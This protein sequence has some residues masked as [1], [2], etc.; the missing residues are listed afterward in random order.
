MS[1][2]ITLIVAWLSSICQV[3]LVYKPHGSFRLVNYMKTMIHMDITWTDRVA[4][5]IYVT[6]LSG[7][8]QIWALAMNKYIMMKWQTL[9]PLFV[10]MNCIHL[11]VVHT[12]ALWSR[13]KRAIHRL[14]PAFVGLIIN[15]RLFS[16]HWRTPSLESWLSSEHACGI[17][18]QRGCPWILALEVLTCLP[19]LSAHHHALSRSRRPPAHDIVHASGAHAL[20]PPWQ[21]HMGNCFLV[22]AISVPAEAASCND[23][24]ATPMRVT[25]W[26]LLISSLSL[27][28]P[29]PQSSFSCC[30]HML[31]N[32][33]ILYFLML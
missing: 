30:I 4:A 33:Q 13:R 11:T 6:S 2:V 27:S 10:P 12:P 16:S 1:P 20:H 22:P 31:E 28:F 19:T 3:L 21:L 5:G 8:A 18:G 14:P 24:C 9:Y 17:K 25:L 32:K 23:V 29:A 26:K 7:C 15:A